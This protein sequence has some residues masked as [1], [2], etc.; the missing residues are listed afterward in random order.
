MP[1]ERDVV[2]VIELEFRLLQLHHYSH[3]IPAKLIEAT[4]DLAQDLSIDI[5]PSDT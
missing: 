1:D 3:G 4:E 5:S 2:L